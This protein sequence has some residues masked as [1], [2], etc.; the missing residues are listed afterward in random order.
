MHGISFIKAPSAYASAEE[1]RIAN[2]VQSVISSHYRWHWLITAG[3]DVTVSS[4][5]QDY[6]LNATDQNKVYA[7]ATA[8]L[9]EGATEQSELLVQSDNQ[10]PATSESGQPFG[11]CLLSPTQ[12]R[13]F[14][15]PDA[16]YTFGWRYYA[17]PVVFTA[18]SENFQIPDAFTDTAKAGVV[19]QVLTYA[20]DTR[21]PEWEKTFKELLNH[22]MRAEMQTTGRMRG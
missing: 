16:T 7:I 5:T 11:V 6:T 1:V 14:P 9:T 18:N 15:N 13:F 20:D 22:H 19:W 21:A 12:I 17:R 10:L 3:Q 8:N 4:G 2:T